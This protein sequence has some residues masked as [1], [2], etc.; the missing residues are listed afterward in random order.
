MDLLEFM[1]E[2]DILHCLALKNMTL[3]ATEL[4]IL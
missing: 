2:L 3:C 1:M 4:D